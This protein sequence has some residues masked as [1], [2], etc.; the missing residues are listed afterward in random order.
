MLG[1]SHQSCIRNLGLPEPSNQNF[2]VQSLDRVKGS[3]VK[4]F[5]GKRCRGLGFKDLGFKDLGFRDLG[6][7]I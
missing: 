2:L 5:K 7:R 4:G 1:L 6:L 3:G